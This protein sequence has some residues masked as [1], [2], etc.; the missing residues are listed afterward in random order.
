MNNFFTADL[1][2][3]QNRGERTT[4]ENWH[5]F[6]YGFLLLKKKKKKRS[7]S[8]NP[9]VEAASS[10][11]QESQTLKKNEHQRAPCSSSRYHCYRCLVFLD[12]SLNNAADRKQQQPASQ[13][14]AGQPHYST[15]YRLS[16]TFR[17]YLLLLISFPLRLLYHHTWHST[18]VKGGRALQAQNR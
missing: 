6:F 7:Q 9:R 13:P 1:G 10:L 3:K 12:K 17:K 15:T 5:N 8:I 16:R 18:S 4:S 11:P 2:S 14:A